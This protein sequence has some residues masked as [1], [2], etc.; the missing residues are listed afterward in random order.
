MKI[1]KHIILLGIIGAVIIS[2]VFLRNGVL[3]VYPDTA[4]YVE[5]VKYYNHEIPKSWSMNYR[6]FKPLYGFVGALITPPFTAEQSILFID[7][8]FFFGLLFSSFYFFKELGFQENYSLIGATFIGTGYPLLKYGLALLTDISGWFFATLTVTIFLVAIRKNSNRLLLLTSVIGF[9]GSLC[10]ETG[11]L[12]LLFAGLYLTFF[13]IKEKDIKYLKKIFYISLPFI[14]LQ[15]I[16]LSVL[17]SRGGSS[18]LAWLKFNNQLVVGLRTPYLFFFTQL[19]TFSILWVYLLVSLYLIF[20]KKIN[21]SFN[22]KI[23]ISCLLVSVL[24]IFAWPEFLS[25]VLYIEFL[26][27]VPLILYAIRFINEKVRSKTL[28]FFIAFVPV[29]I[30]MFLFSL[31]GNGS[32]FDVLRAF[33]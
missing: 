4:V 6:S 18:F 31:A 2:L 26:F 16:F 25:R 1:N 9:F 3:N 12:G 19:S 7:V 33:I 17:I 30:S 32:L 14:L 29:L 10:K 24:P 13:L 21:I 28:L 8:I 11:I 20:R 23:I 22:N 15:A 5:Q 27:I